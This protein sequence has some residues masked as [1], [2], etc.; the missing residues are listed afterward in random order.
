MRL[1]GRDRV[2]FSERYWLRVK[3]SPSLSLF[4]LHS[5]NIPIAFLKALCV[6]Q[7][8]YCASLFT[9]QKPNKFLT[10]QHK[11]MYTALPLPS[12][13]E[14]G[15]YDLRHAD[16]FAV[17]QAL[18][19]YVESLYI[20]YSIRGKLSHFSHRQAHDSIS[21]SLSL[22]SQETLL[23]KRFLQRSVGLHSTKQHDLQ[24]QGSIPA[25]N[26][27]LLMIYGHT[28]VCISWAHWKSHSIDYGHQS[29]ESLIHFPI[30]S[31][32]GV[33]LFPKQHWWNPSLRS[34]FPFLSSR[35]LYTRMY[36]SLSI[37]VFTAELMWK[38]LYSTVSLH[39]MPVPLVPIYSLP[40]F[41]PFP[42][43]AEKYS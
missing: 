37:H 38:C 3:S 40:W 7:S 24:E 25:Q 27:S 15:A 8:V 5:H 32:E 6:V 12:P 29:R 20:H 23:H 31:N 21:S 18:C 10:E 4:S 39:P 1:F 33:S 17:T 19:Q 26:N 41:T 35:L 9:I 16:I 30:C 28:F 34:Y 42:F 22:R 14:K 43:P 2:P 13:T 11:P 36:I